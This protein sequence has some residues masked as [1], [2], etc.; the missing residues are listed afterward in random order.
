MLPKK[1]I[2][3][4]LHKSYTPFQ[5]LFFQGD[6]QTIAGRYW[7]NP[8]REE[9]HKTENK[10]FSTAKDVKVLAH[11]NEVHL[12]RRGGTILSL[13][14]LPGSGQSAYVR[15]LAHVAL[16]RGLRVIRLNIRNCGGTEHLAPTLYHSGLTDDLRAVVEQLDPEP[17]VIVGF[18]MGGNIALKLAGEW[19]DSPPA[20]VRGVCGVSVP[21]LLDACSKRLGHWR[22]RIYEA[23]CL[24]GLKRTVRK[25]Q[26]LMP[27]LFES[28]RC[29]NVRSIYEFDDQ[30]TAPVFGFR[31]ADHYY[32]QSSSAYFLKSI[33]IPT[34][35]VQAKDDP[36]IP[37]EAFTRAKIET[38]SH[39]KLMA[40]E[41]GGHVSFLSRCFPRFWVQ[42]LAVSFAE[43]VLAEGWGG[44][45][46]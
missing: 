13:H 40:T 6:L 28:L 26:S 8:F 4:T 9:A 36:F 11:I 41:W 37:F 15:A 14:G 17:L 45:D 31:N 3:P 16:T 35:L 22:N 30:I 19:G 23:R 20:N 43:D 25:K 34:L 38:C 33:R 5:P 10:L 7:P 29:S 39:V 2:F 21:I 27:E 46:V 32:K 24:E 18:S 12:G 44:M 1:E 42:N